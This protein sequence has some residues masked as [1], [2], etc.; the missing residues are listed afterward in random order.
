MRRESEEIRERERERE[1]DR[2]RES[3]EIRERER[4][5]ETERER[6]SDGFKNRK[7]LPPPLPNLVTVS[8]LNL[9]PYSYNHLCVSPLSSTP[10]T[11][12]IYNLYKL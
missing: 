10:G 9:F 7:T 12:N 6:E 8:H 4:E 1:R 3:E 2:E 5:R 11:Q